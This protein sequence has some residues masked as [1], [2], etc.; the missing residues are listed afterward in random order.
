MRCETPA[1]LSALVYTVLIEQVAEIMGRR[2]E[3]I[4]PREG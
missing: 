2:P 1:D 4:D 3:D